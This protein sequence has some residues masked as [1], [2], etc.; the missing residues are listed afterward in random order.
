[1]I[2]GESLNISEEDLNTIFIWNEEAVYNKVELESYHKVV[3][4]DTYTDKYDG[5][6]YFRSQCLNEG[7]YLK[8]LYPVYHQGWEMDEWAATGTKDGKTY[9]LTTN[10]GYLK[11]ELTPSLLDTIKGVFRG[12]KG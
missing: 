2:R 7:Y 8:A 12:I 10:H 6:S 3:D 9:D 1:M 5:S 11:A 4:F